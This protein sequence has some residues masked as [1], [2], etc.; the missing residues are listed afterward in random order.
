MNRPTLIVSLLIVAG[1]LILMGASYAYFTTTA[2]SN[3]QVITSGTLE[4]TYETGQD[5]HLENAYPTTEDEA[6]VHQ[7]KIRNTGT[8]DTEYNLYLSNISLT[9]N[10]MDTTSSDIKYTLYES[11]DD[12]SA[13]KLVQSGSFGAHDGYFAG[14]KNLLLLENI[15]LSSGEEQNYILKV[16]LQETG[17]LQNEE[18][19][20]DLNFRVMTSTKNQIINRKVAVYGLGNFVAYDGYLDEISQEMINYTDLIGKVLRKSGRY[21]GSYAEGNEFTIEQFLEGIKTGT[22]TSHGTVNYRNALSSLGSED[23]VTFSIGLHDMYTD[24]LEIIDSGIND[25]DEIVNQLI[26]GLDDFIRIYDELLTEVFTIYDGYIILLGSPNFLIP[27]FQL[28]EE[29]INCWDKVFKVYDEKM[30]TLATKY[31]VDYISGY[32]LFKGKEEQCLE[33]VEQLGMKLTLETV[34]E[35]KNVLMDKVSTYLI[36]NPVLLAIGDSVANG[37][38]ASG[39]TSSYKNGYNEIIYNYLHQQNSKTEVFYESVGG[40]TIENYVEAIK[41]GKMTIGDQVLDYPLRDV[42]STLSNNDILTLSITGNDII[43]EFVFSNFIDEWL[44]NQAKTLEEAKK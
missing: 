43:Q 6:G 8:L 21:G 22:V 31:N 7:F 4:L 33:E 1:T 32:N 14:D 34:T 16:W 24:Y 9:K 19:G 23:I 25:K 26:Q 38:L 17:V 5:I 42:L 41:T 3:G 35:L 18:Q 39:T 28:N 20:M 40:A 30:Q 27:L 12:Y 15:P 37:T 36:K 11:N 29:E 10:G 44:F 2:T 13:Q